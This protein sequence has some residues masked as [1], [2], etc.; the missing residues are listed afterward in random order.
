M[1][2]R[3]R[4]FDSPPPDDLRNTVRLLNA[5]VAELT[6]RVTQLQK[7]DD[8]LKENQELKKLAADG[9]PTLCSVGVGQPQVSSILPFGCPPSSIFKNSITA[10]LVKQDYE[11]SYLSLVC[12]T[13]R[14]SAKTASKDTHAVI[15]R[16][17][18]DR[19]SSGHAEW[20]LISQI[21]STADIEKPVNIWRHNSRR[22]EENSTKPRPLK[23]AFQ[24]SRARDV[25]LE[26][27]NKTLPSWRTRFPGQRPI[28]RRDMTPPE[29]RLLYLLRKHCY[30]KNQEAGR[31]EFVVRDLSIIKL[32][33]PRNFPNQSV[34]SS[35]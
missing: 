21:C 23:I 16:L 35:Q 14:H 10:D 5:T 26:R 28:A 1:T 15:E 6:D 4:N 18:D 12:D 3:R 24:T 19:S 9:H 29:L 8:V 33:D 30:D 31:I 25:F 34:V 11:L 2:K 20:D 17:Y 13:L 22:S 7:L 27:F 32:K